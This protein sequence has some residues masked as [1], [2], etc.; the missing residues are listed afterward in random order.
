MRSHWTLKK[1]LI[2]TLL[3]A[4]KSEGY[5]LLSPQVREAQLDWHEVVSAADL[6]QGFS[7]TQTAGSYRLLPASDDSWFSISHGAPSLKNLTYKPRQSLVNI[8]KTESGITF[9][10]VEN[11][12]VK[13][14]VIGARACDVAALQI[15]EKVFVAG[16]YQDDYFRANRDSLFIIAVNCSRAVE[17]CFCASMDCGPK[18]ESG[19]DLS[20]TELEDSFVVEVGSEAGQLLMESLNLP[21]ATG[22]DVSASQTL[23]EQCASS[24]Q[25]KMPQQHLAETLQR[26]QHSDHWAEV[27]TRC[28]SC[29]NCTMVCPTCFCHSIEETPDLVRQSSERVRVWDSCFNPEHGYIHGKNMRPTTAERYRMWM[30]HKLGTWIDQ[31]GSS[32]CTGCGRCV[33][34]CPVG[35]DLVAEAIAVMGKEK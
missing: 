27:A 16:E 4:L 15:Q 2:E 7:D 17:T 18:V 29:A 21:L 14:A 26:Q 35:I 24:Q 23:I 13:T 1:N 28:L 5:L 10:A 6:K 3:T 22:S 33:T 32:G 19:F 30:S 25:K 34:W 11:K 9:K 8:I 31:F 12:A 20:L